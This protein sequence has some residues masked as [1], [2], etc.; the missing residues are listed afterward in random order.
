MGRS[1]D[2]ALIWPAGDE[3]RRTRLLGRMQD[4]FTRLDGVLDPAAGSAMQNLDLV[5]GLEI[6]K[7]RLNRSGF[8]VDQGGTVVTTADVV[9]GCTRITIDDAHEAEVAT[10][11][12]GLGIAVLRP[13]ETLAP[14]AVAAFQQAVP[15]LQSD[16]AVAGYS[17][18]GVLGAPTLTFGHLADLRGLD[19][20]DN[21]KRLALNALDGDAGGPVVDAGGAVLGMLLPNP[22][23]ERKLPQG[24]SFAAD[25]AVLKRLLEEAGIT[26]SKT[27]DTDQIAPEALTDRAAG[28]TVLVSCWE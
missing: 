16:I 7:P 14:I 28:M 18:G 1:R 19:G 17:Y 24:V 21:V 6:R 15:R 2:L 23:D 4:S 11:D 20:E 26:P 12:D 25:G 10:R 8:Y 13:L 22:S 3:E 27:S 9:Q 5:S